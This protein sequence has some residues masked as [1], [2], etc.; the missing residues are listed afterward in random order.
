[1]N[2]PESDNTFQY[3]QYSPV[4]NHWVDLSSEVNPLSTYASA[5]PSGT[6]KSM[7]M[8][9][10]PVKELLAVF[11]DHLETLGYDFAQNLSFLSGDQDNV[12]LAQLFSELA[13]AGSEW[14]LGT[15]DDFPGYSSEVF[16]DTVVDLNASLEAVNLAFDGRNVTLGDVYSRYGFNLE[17]LSEEL[18]DSYMLKRSTEQS[19]QVFPDETLLHKTLSVNVFDVPDHMMDNLLYGNFV[20]LDAYHSSTYSTATQLVLGDP[21]EGLYD[22]FATRMMGWFYANISA[23]YTFVCGSDDA[24]FLYVN[25]ALVVSNPGEH[26]YI[27]QYGDVY[28][29]RGYHDMIWYT[30]ENVGYFY[31][32]VAYRHNVSGTNDFTVIDNSVFASIIPQYYPNPNSTDCSQGVEVFAGMPDEVLLNDMIYGDFDGLE[33]YF[34]GFSSPSVSFDLYEPQYGLYDRFVTRV[35]GQFYVSSS[36]SV[37]FRSGSDDASFL[38]VDGVLVVNNPGLHGYHHE[39][40]TVYLTI[41]YHHMIWYAVEYTGSFSANLQYLDWTGTYIS[42]AAEDFHQTCNIHPVH[43][44]TPPDD[45]RLDDCL[46]GDF[47]NIDEYYNRTF[48]VNECALTDAFGLAEKFVT[49]MTSR[50]YAVTSDTY[51]FKSES[52][53]TSFLVVDGVQVVAQVE[54]SHA[55]GRLYLSVGF[56]DIIWYTVHNEGNYSAELSFQRN[57]SGSSAYI[58]VGQSFLLLTNPDVEIT[59]SSTSS[60]ADTTSNRMRWGITFGFDDNSTNSW[61][62]LTGVMLGG[63]NGVAFGQ[64]S[65][66]DSNS[67]GVQIY[68]R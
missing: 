64:G 60:T 68:A 8:N 42:V 31:S 2:S 35:Q 44:Y 52:T 46:S 67:L 59:S 50:F 38:F 41:G 49:R 23:T 30:V 34:I 62:P 25:G 37:T 40:G 48:N 33:S 4:P 47:T 12:T 21:Q 43:V 63:C 10:V 15:A 1:M 53:N 13:A 65:L 61:V 3:F 55:N 27:E 7:A 24:S 22:R 16:N 14:V 39:Y 18:S 56:H 6:F 17:V 45:I 26:S 66:Y 36:A 58:L 11:P 29:T 32:Q 51:S 57:T 5:V 19:G 28:L 20:S 54:H 9:V